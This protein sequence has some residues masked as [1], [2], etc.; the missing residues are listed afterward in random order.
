PITNTG[1]STS[2]TCPVG[3][4]GIYSSGTAGGGIVIVHAG[5]VTGTGII[6][7]S[8]QNALQ[9]ENDGAGGGGAGGTILMFA[10][11]GGLGGLTA[12]ATGGN[13]GITWPEDAPGATFPG[14]R[15]G[16]GG[17]GGGGVIFSSA[18]LAAS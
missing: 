2:N 1:N 9:V 17:G 12:N 6:T 8:G 7:S 4:T 3:C 13:G 10:N 15:H 18:P 5:S 14:N 11:S 16:P